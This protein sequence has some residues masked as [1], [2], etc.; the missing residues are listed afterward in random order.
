MRPKVRPALARRPGCTVAGSRPLRP[1]VRHSLRTKLAHEGL[2]MG[3]SDQPLLLCDDVGEDLLPALSHLGRE[4]TW[5][6]RNPTWSHVG[7]Q[8]R[9]SAPQHAAATPRTGPRPACVTV[10]ACITYL[11][12]YLLTYLGRGLFLP[13]PRTSG[14]TTCSH[15]GTHLVL[16]TRVRSTCYLLLATSHVPRPTAHAPPRARSE[17]GRARRASPPARCAP[18]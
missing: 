9:R 12:T 8:G 17:R 7:V 5:T 11:L 13:R 18:R 6:W 1:R 15:L 2:E 16:L 3:A 4:E 10:S 14:L